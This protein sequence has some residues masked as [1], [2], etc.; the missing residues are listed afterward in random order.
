[1]PIRH[2]IERLSGDV[3]QLVDG[4]TMRDRDAI[5]S[6]LLV[7]PSKADTMGPTQ[8]AEWWSATRVED[9]LGRRVVLVK[10]ELNTPLENILPEVEARNALGS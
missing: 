9:L 6:R 8:V 5:H 7:K 3:S 10:K 1:M 2:T 4:V